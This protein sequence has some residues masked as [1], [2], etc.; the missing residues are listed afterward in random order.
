MLRRFR[1]QSVP[2]STRAELTGLRS[3]TRTA[4]KE[5]RTR[6]A[7]QVYKVVVSGSQNGNLG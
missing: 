2:G 4:G 1:L 6:V 5:I 7:G 3:W